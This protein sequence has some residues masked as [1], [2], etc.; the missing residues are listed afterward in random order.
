MSSN[1]RFSD[2]SNISDEDS[3]YLAHAC[4]IGVIDGDTAGTFRPYD[5]LKRSE[6]AKVIYSYMNK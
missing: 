6:C 5:S 1:K 2:V 3:V 4:G